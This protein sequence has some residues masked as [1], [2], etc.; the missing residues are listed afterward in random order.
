MT[1]GICLTEKN[2]IRLSGYYEHQEF[3]I[4]KGCLS[5]A[6]TK[7][8]VGEKLSYPRK[9]YQLDNTTGYFIEITKAGTVPPSQ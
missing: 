3:D 1:C 4:C 2:V 8:K 5:I 6:L 7:I 9:V